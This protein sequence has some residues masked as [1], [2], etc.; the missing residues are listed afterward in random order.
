MPGPQ[1]A[2]ALLQPGQPARP[3]PRPARRGADQVTTF[4]SNID[5]NARSQRTLISYGNGT[6]STYAYDPLT[7][8]LVTLTT[9]S[10]TQR[11]QDLRYTYDPVGNPTLIRDDAQQRIFFRNRVVDPSDSYT[12]DALY[13]LTEATGREHL[14]Q[15]A[16]PVPPGATDEGRVGLP[17]P[18]DGAAMTRYT[19]R[20]V[21]DEVG[22]LLQ[23]AHRSAH[24]AHGGWTRD[25]R[26]R[27]PSLLEPARHSN[28]LTTANTPAVTTPERFSYDE[29]GN[30]TAMPEIPVLAWDEYDRLHATARGGQ[31]TTYYLYDAAG[32]RARKVTERAL[33]EAASRKH[34][35]IYIGSFEVYRE[36]DTLGAVT[37]ERETLSV[38]DDKQRIALVE[39]RTAGTD[40][41]PRELIRYQLSNHLGSSMLELDQDARVISY[42]EYYPYGSTSYQAVRA[43]IAGS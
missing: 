38:R 30:T 29:Q 34:E 11:L 35:R 13:R 24:P 37:L 20:Y 2:V 15:S 36:Y 14:G 33:A 18:G 10:G 3:N 16:P 5:Y 39:T 28:R 42:E 12:Y 4:V 41:G 32:Q 31:E 40:N 19:E 27:E 21:Y 7:F 43:G 6:S 1:H 25:Y 22:N 8:R 17:Q 9:L 23:M 26:Y